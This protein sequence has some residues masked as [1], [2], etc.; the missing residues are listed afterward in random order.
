MTILIRYSLFAVI[1]T[2]FN[3]LFQDI[4]VRLID[5]RHGL[6]LSVLAGTAAGL[7]VKYWLDKQYIFNYQTRSLSHNSQTFMLYT[8]MG[9]LTTVIFWGFE[10][11]FHFIFAT[12]EMR[13]AG[14]ILGLAIGY[15]IK[16][17]LDKRFVFADL[18]PD[19]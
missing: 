17:Q 2:V 4:V 8:V 12:K 14:G 3:I 18:K 6:V 11:A 5:G 1:A 13:Y 16:Y 19:E 9:L 7:V 15:Y 10:A